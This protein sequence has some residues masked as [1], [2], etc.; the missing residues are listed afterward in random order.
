MNKESV[1]VYDWNCI[2]WTR[3]LINSKKETKREREIERQKKGA[4][5]FKPYLVI[6]VNSKGDWY[7]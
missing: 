7:G 4:I 3:F 5:E 6:A 2:E 1:C